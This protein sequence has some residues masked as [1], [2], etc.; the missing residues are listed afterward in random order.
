[1]KVVVCVEVVGQLSKPFFKKPDLRAVFGDQIFQGRGSFLVIRGA[2]KKFTRFE[3]RRDPDERSHRRGQGDIEMN[4]N[5]QLRP[6]FEFANGS[7]F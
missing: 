4:S 5:S 7:F 6:F 2:F 3:K 1:M